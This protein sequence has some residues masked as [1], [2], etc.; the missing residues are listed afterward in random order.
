MPTTALA[1]RLA[2]E[3]STPSILATTPKLSATNH[4]SPW[5]SASSATT[6][7]AGKQIAQ[8]AAT[9]DRGTFPHV[10]HARLVEESGLVYGP[11]PG[12]STLRE[13]RARE[14]RP[15]LD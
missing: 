7:S 9:S 6:P 11:I 15:W 1:A 5:T 14:P 4:A 2:P 13:L 10:A 3:M 12:Q 8:R